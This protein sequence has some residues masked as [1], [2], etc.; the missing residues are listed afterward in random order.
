MFNARISTSRFGH[1]AVVRVMILCAMTN[2]PPAHSRPS[3]SLALGAKLQNGRFT[4]GK[5]LGRGGF[6][7]TY[8][9]HDHQLG[10]LVAIKELFPVECLRRDLRVCPSRDF[11]AAELDAARQKFL[12]EARTLARFRH[13]G[14]VQV[15]DCFEENETAYL[16]M[17]YLQGQTLQQKVEEGGALPVAQ[18]L[19]FISSIGQALQEVHQTQTIHRDIKPE[20]MVLC[21]ATNSNSANSNGANV[22]SAATRA[23]LID[24]G[25]NKQVAAPSFLGTQP[26]SRTTA[27]GSPG[28]AA[29]EQYGQGA[30]LGIQTD[31]YGLGATLYFLLTAQVP[32]SAVERINAT[33]PPAHS[34]NPAIAPHISDAIERALKMNAKER[35]ANV[36]EWLQMLAAAPSI[37]SPSSSASPSSPALSPAYA[38]TTVLSA[39][40]TSSQSP[41]SS[42]SSTRFAGVFAQEIRVSARVLHW[43][44]LC[45]CC[46]QN[47]N[48]ISNAVQKSR[49]GK[50][51]IRANVNEW[52]SYLDDFSCADCRRHFQIGTAVS[53][54]SNEINR[55]QSESSTRLA[56]WQQQS[57]SA[58]QGEIL[59]LTQS[60]DAVTKA[61]QQLQKVDEGEANIGAL[62]AVGLPSLG[63]ATVLFSSLIAGLLTSAMCVVAGEIWRTANA[64]TRKQQRLD[65]ARQ[66]LAASEKQLL[67]TQQQVENMRRQEAQRLQ[68]QEASERQ[69]LQDHQ[70]ALSQSQLQMANAMRATCTCDHQNQAVVLASSYGAQHL[71]RF[72]NADFAREFA[73]LNHEKL[74]YTT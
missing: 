65:A 71:F 69:S 52:P 62:L 57:E 36:R 22:Q 70:H 25:L 3:E 55:L 53:S 37:S 18:A 17:E 7:I 10:R 56:V 27:L 30:Q 34:L 48:S 33:M 40:S 51:F 16:V 64:A 29:P 60:K 12:I 50:R 74:I 58:L 14:I 63:I 45:A 21:D 41:P 54:A 38:P 19:H 59:K 15:F 8:M 5:V 23:V 20:N 49:Q 61:R 43:P 66:G 26:L 6:G 1:F 44:L 32:L 28:F 42:S 11:S 72:S 9:G 31:I 24:F 73:A 2:Q 46:G 47:N 35:P 67:Q 13:D 39:P 4:V 68:N